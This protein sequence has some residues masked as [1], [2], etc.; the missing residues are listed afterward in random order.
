M[1]N[2][3]FNFVLYPNDYFFCFANFLLTISVECF[4]DGFVTAIVRVGMLEHLLLLKLTVY[5]YG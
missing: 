1:L 4:F 2:I 3:I 5:S